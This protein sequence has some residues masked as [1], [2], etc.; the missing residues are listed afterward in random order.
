MYR[1]WTVE[2]KD[3]ADRI[4]SMRH[5]LFEALQARG[6]IICFVYMINLSCNIFI[7]ICT[8]FQAGEICWSFTYLIRIGSWPLNEE[9]YLRMEIVITNACD[10]ISE[11]VD[12]PSF[13]FPVRWK[14]ELCPCYHSFN[15]WKNILMKFV[16]LKLL[17][18]C[19]QKREKK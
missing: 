9:D 12:N 1:E 7:I 4:I 6:K 16:A 14:N 13:I 3:M 17:F 2:L 18:Q 11:S 15:W 5:Q 19:P 8:C 10:I